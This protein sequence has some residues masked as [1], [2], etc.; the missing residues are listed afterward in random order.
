MKKNNELFK[1]NSAQIFDFAIEILFLVIVFI[2]PT[3]YDRRL[4]IVF[5][6]AKIAWLR[7]LVAVVLSVWSVKL[8]ITHKHRFVRTPLD[9]PVVSYI[10]AV[11][12]ATI[13][14]VHVYTSILGFYG[15]YEGL[16]TWYL[17]V[18]LFFIATNYIRTFEQIKR[19][20][21]NVV[22]AATLMA[23][24]S[25]IQ[26]RELDPYMWGGVVTWQRVIGT[27]G[28]PNFLAGYMLMALFMNLALLMFDR[29]E[30]AG[31]INWG[32]QLIPIG[33]FLFTQV[34]YVVMIYNLDAQNIFLWYFGFLAIT[35]SALMFSYTYE[36]LHP[37]IFS[38][39]MGLTLVLNYICI[40]YT[41]S[42]GGYMGLFTGGAVFFLVAGR[43][44]IFE[45]WKRL[46][47]VGILIFLISALAMIQ[48]EY[49]PFQRF[50]SEVTTEKA[51]QGAEES[52]L[53]LKGAAGS[54]GETWKSAAEII[55]N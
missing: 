32:D 37:L 21:L 46:T 51:Q 28:Q 29:K 55:A 48:P 9:W 3:I 6:G 30:K 53:E 13:T 49:S 44:W 24:Y 43:K 18:L 36:A 47:A 35:A 38:A 20:A 50:A 19:I 39:L 54:R 5:S 52:K 23:V 33:Y 22:S 45:S 7:A 15:R 1:W 10:F 4:G 11:T 26:R 17:F 40:L 8:L 41:Q 34:I 2:I 27:I 31:E 16:T 25:I 42:R 14:S 12:I